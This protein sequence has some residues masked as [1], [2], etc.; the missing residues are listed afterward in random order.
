MARR[1]SGPFEASLDA[2][3]GRKGRFDVLDKNRT[4]RVAIVAARLVGNRQPMPQFAI[5]GMTER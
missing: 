2:K 4:R 5:T 1:I 3:A